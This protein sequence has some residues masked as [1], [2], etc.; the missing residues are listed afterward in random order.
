MTSPSDQLIHAATHPFAGETELKF[1]AEADLRERIDASGASDIALTGTADHLAKANRRKPRHP[2]ALALYLVAGLAMTA[3]IVQ[4]AIQSQSLRLFLQQLNFVTGI[5]Y[6]SETPADA[7]FPDLSPAQ[8]LLLFGDESAASGPDRWKP[9]WESDPDNPAYLAE[10]A[11]A[12]FHEHD[13]L[14]DEI[15]EAANRIDPDNGWH[16][17]LQAAALV[18]DAVEK[19]YAPSHAKRTRPT[20]VWKI[21][22]SAQLDECLQ[23]IHLAAQKPV[24]ESHFGPMAENRLPLLPPRTDYLGQFPAIAYMAGQ[25]ST[26]ISYR[27]LMDALCAGAQQR[28][29]SG[30]RDG[31]LTLV[32]DWENLTRRMTSN[33]ATL[34]HALVAKI[35]FYQPA[36]NF[37]DAAR[38]L[39]LADEAER[40]EK[41]YQM[42]LD[43][44]T[45][46]ERRRNR[47]V[48]GVLLEQKGSIFSS[49]LLAMISNQVES[50]PPLTAADIRPQ[51]RAEHAFFARFTSWLAALVLTSA[52]AA[53]FLLGLGQSKLARHLSGSLVSLLRP[54]DWL[55]IAGAGIVLPFGYYFGITRLTELGANEW[56]MQTTA[57]IQPACQ[58]GGLLLAVL[59]TPVALASWRLAKRGSAIRLAATRLWRSAALWL[60]VACAWLSIPVSGAVFLLR[61]L[62]VI[63]TTFIL[64][65][66]PALWLLAAQGFLLF[67]NTHHTLR[68]A[69]LARTLTP[70]W[71]FAALIFLAMIPCHH[72]EERQWIRQDKLLVPSPALTAYEAQVTEI[73]KQELQQ[74]MTEILPDN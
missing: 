31:F 13:E 73:L 20:P 11:K 43:E 62:P 48:Y 36:Q 42:A 23:L 54:I 52:A 49:L 68:R 37:R 19:V 51:R 32:D 61:G 64:L 69:T 14:S 25:T 16:L 70:A 33:A 1:A 65:A 63:E 26:C 3:S 53:P 34:V 6:G 55:W 56:N 7:G 17:S 38:Q 28:A 27:K 29:A 22:D 67:G 71:A 59:I 5:G 46:K 15:L 74:R 21:K 45:E 58:I 9:L 39:G 30:D 57:F 35:N 72:F 4:V 60:A 44:R 10:Y 41:L 18:E 24:Y 50:P 47:S 2:W 40:F 66:I 8:R 12:Y